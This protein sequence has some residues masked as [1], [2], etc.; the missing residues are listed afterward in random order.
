VNLFPWVQY[1]NWS[2]GQLSRSS[3]GGR[4]LKIIDLIS[5]TSSIRKCN[6]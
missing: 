1:D 3:L 4:K 6:T 2:R 5:H